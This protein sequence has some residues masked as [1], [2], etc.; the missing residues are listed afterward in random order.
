MITLQTGRLL[1]V[2][3]PLHV[4]RMRQQ[5]DD[6]RAD[7]TLSVDPAGDPAPAILRVHFP[8]QWPGDA[9]VF[10][11]LWERLLEA[12]PDYDMMGGTV[13]D[14]TECVAVGQMT[15]RPLAEDPGTVELGYGI[16]P[17]Y[18]GRGYATEMARRL[19]RW[20]VEGADIRAII[21]N[22]LET[23]I[24]SIRVLEKVGFRRAGQR[25]DDEGQM[26]L[27]HYRSL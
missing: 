18:E 10:L 6:F 14:R 15:L 9:V 25:E 8:P 12:D 3:T 26:I 27:W 5:R 13:I 7:V 21:A 20:A 4:I 22:C 24:A 11:P 23:N 2:E 17:A 16:N 1:L 19:V